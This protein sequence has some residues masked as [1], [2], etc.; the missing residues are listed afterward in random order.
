MVIELNGE[1]KVKILTNIKEIFDQEENIGVIGSPSSTNELAVDLLGTAVNK[2]LVGKFSIFNYYQ[3]GK[4]HYALGQITE[5]TMQ[6]I[7]TQDPTMRGIIRQRGR[8]DPITE[9]QD[10]HTAKMVISSVFANNQNTIEPSIFGTVP[11]TGTPIRMFDEGIMN[12]LLADY[13][14]ELFCLGKTYGTNINLPM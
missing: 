9:K 3:D 7:W 5:I 13:K 14:E 8:V 1:N 10:I 6:N 2:G 11:S 12:A 4:D